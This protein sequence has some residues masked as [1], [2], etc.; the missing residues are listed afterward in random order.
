VYFLVLNAVRR[1]PNLRRAIWTLLV[2]GAILGSM[3][4]YQELTHRYDQ[5][6]AGL[7]QRNL[8]RGQGLDE[9]SSGTLL[10]KR[11]TIYVAN[12][13]AGPIGDPNRYA[14]I[15]IVLLPLGLFRVRDERSRAL[16]LAAAGATLLVLCGILLSYSRGG[17]I[18]LVMLLVAL[19]ALGYVRLRHVALGLVVVTVLAA[20]VA[21]GFM[22]RIGSIGG[23]AGLLSDR[24]TRTTA[25]DGATRGRLTEMLAALN[26]FLDYPAVGVGPGQFTPYYSQDYMD[27]PEV[28]FRAVRGPRRAH[29]LYFELAAETGIVGLVSFLAIV[30]VSLARLWR[31]RRRW[32]REQPELSHLAAGF[33]L[34]LVAYLGTAVFLQLAYQ[35]YFFLLLALAGATVQILK[36]LEADFAAAPPAQSFLEGA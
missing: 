27:Q 30:M 14:Q 8:E 4:V 24:E 22:G 26:V 36:S 20:L 28:A 3:S 15:L 19:I 1:L 35:R 32:A 11:D 21:P 34:A 10:R 2:V 17:F 18:T 9:P 7:A 29:S 13:A 12:R 16:K 5:Q 6:F 31:A 33:W 23:V 25:A